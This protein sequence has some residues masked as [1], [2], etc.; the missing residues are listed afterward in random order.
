MTLLEA[1]INAF[2]LPELRNKLLFT[3]GLLAIYRLFAN[4]SIPNAQ[5]AAL[6]A[7]F[8][9]QP[10]LRLLNLFSGGGLSTFSLV[11]IGVNPYIN[12]T[13]LMHRITWVSERITATSND[14]V[15]R[16]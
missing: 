16:P 10:L 4:V 9:N 3:A 15:L 2:R 14:A 11:A 8:N 12:A 1:L 6:Q 7:L 13:I 5:Q